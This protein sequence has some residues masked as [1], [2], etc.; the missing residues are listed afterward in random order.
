MLKD[1]FLIHYKQLY[2]CKWYH[3]IYY[4]F[5]NFWQLLNFKHKQCVTIYLCLKEDE[6]SSEMFYAPYIPIATNDLKKE[7]PKGVIKI[8]DCFTTDENGRVLY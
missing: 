5:Y 4:W 6:P 7:L 2:N 1:E 3:Y 8:N